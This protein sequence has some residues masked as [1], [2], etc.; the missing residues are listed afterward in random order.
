M[1]AFQAECQALGTTLERVY[2]QGAVMSSQQLSDLRLGERTRRIFAEA[3]LHRVE[4]VASMPAEHAMEIPQLAP[5]TVAEV[6]AA[7]MFA[8]EL[9]AN[10][11]L[12]KLP[13]PGDSG[14]LFD[15]LPHGVNQLPPREREAVVLRAGV[16]DRVHDLD[17]VAR[18]IDCPADQVATLE[19][20][21]LN[22]LLSRP[23]SLEACWRLEALCNHLGLAWEDDRLPAVVAALYPNTRASFTRLVVWLM[24]EKARIVAEL[25]GRVFTEPQ[26]I[27][28]FDEM[29]VAAIGRYGDMPAETLTRHVLEALTPT[30]R[31]LYP[32]VAVSERVQVLG[33]AVRSDDGVF[34]L[35]DAPIPGVDD[36]HIRAL[37]GLIGALQKL[38]SARISALTNEVNRRLPRPYHVND[39]YVR[40]WLTRHPDLFVQ[41]DIDRFKLASMDV[42]ILCGLASSWQPG[43]AA[44]S[45]AAGASRPGGAA[46]ERAYER[47]AKEITEYL[48]REGAQ[49]IGRIRSHLY[50]RFVGIA[51]ADA[52]IAAHPRR[53]SRDRSGL[54]TLIDNVVPV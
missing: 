30:D 34:R 44:Q 15:G 22:L 6:R 40:S 37:N 32:D 12:Y 27:A 35:P 10:R 54:I 20:Y 16:G 49:P 3:G 23:S 7:V 14:D 41:A 43:D 50:G 25:E 52:V 21:A 18:M 48:R 53:F 17:E 4:D 42:D 29:V 2:E 39:Q 8:A 19:H 28:H 9:E 33:P 45:V 13:P 24:R 47:M 1:Q 38:G 11:K 5:S 31:E 46:I 36:R 51:S 26:G